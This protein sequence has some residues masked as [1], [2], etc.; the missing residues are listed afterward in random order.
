M[1][2]ET[3]WFFSTEQQILWSHRSRGGWGGVGPEPVFAS[4][5]LVEAPLG[6]LIDRLSDWLLPERRLSKNEWVTKRQRKA[7]VGFQSQ[8]KRSPSAAQS[9]TEKRSWKRFAST[10]DIR[11]IEMFC[12]RSD[13]KQDYVSRQQKRKHSQSHPLY[14]TAV[15]DNSPHDSGAIEVCDLFWAERAIR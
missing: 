4:G 1:N 10:T 12:L 8:K 7:F 6:N 5:C 2:Q 15:L 13:V 9:S 11:L 3:H 14:S